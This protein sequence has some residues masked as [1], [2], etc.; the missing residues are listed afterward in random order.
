MAAIHS[1]ERA[2]LNGVRQPT[3]LAGLDVLRAVAALMI[4]A[5]HAAVKAEWQPIESA[6]PIGQMGRRLFIV[7]SAFLLFMPYARG[8]LWLGRDAPES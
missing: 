4:V 3:R 6:W 2:A 8:R 5:F 1:E 7:L